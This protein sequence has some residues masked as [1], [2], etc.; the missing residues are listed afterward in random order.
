LQMRTNP[1]VLFA[2][3]VCGVEGYVESIAAGLIAGIN[4]AAITRSDDLIKCPLESAIGSLLN[5]I[6][7]CESKNFQP[8]NMTFGLLPQLDEAVRRRVRSK[9]D[10][11]RLQI[12]TATQAFDEWLKK[13]NNPATYT[14]AE[15]PV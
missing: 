13:I 3:Q 10:R 6:A 7:N 15:A 1:R 5:Y 12:E 11:H 14:A 4:A 9:Q 2:G 8:M